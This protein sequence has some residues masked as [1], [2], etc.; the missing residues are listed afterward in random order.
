MNSIE[1][2]SSFIHLSCWLIGYSRAG[3][4]LYTYVKYQV[5]ANTVRT[6]IEL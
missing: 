6:S 3:L 5:F 4:L 2:R 1:C